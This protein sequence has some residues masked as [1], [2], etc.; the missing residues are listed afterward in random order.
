M[1]AQLSLNLKKPNDCLDC[2]I[3]SD[4]RELVGLVFRLAGNYKLTDMPVFQSFISKMVEK[5]L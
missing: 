5:S 3:K 1:Q 4:S 2:L